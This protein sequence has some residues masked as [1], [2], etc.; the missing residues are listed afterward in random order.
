M[1]EFINRNPGWTTLIVFI[2]MGGLVEIVEALAK[3]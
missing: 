1:K 2:V 3:R